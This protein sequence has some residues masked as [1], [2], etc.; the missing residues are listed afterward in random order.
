MD[1]QPLT[2]QQY[3]SALDAGYSHDQIVQNELQRK[4]NSTPA[5]TNGGGFLKSLL[6]PVATMIARP[7][8]AGA[9]LL[10]A[11]S[12]SVDATTKKLTGGLVAPVPQNA[13][14]VKKDVGRGIQTVALGAGP[15]SMALSGAGFGLG[16]SLEQ[17]ND[18]F[19]VQT[20]LQ[21]A[22]GAGAGKILGLVG[23]PLFNVAG[24]VV[25]SVTP[26][27]LKDLVSQGNKAIIDFAAQ[28]E[29]LP[30]F[31]KDIISATG[32]KINQIGSYCSNLSS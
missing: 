22:L 16:G 20:A 10:G 12:Q 15:E 23:K 24:K 14:D 7:F 11:S 29:I 26:A 31:G 1:F 5:P 8:Q 27:F 18:L 4:A 21:T 25:G 19:S 30:Q 6:S 13:A 9:E 28:H 2:S 3:Q 32:E 17:G